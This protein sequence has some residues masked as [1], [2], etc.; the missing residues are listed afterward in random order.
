M[1]PDLDRLERMRAKHREFE[2]VALRMKG[3]TRHVEVTKRGV[4][5]HVVESGN[6][7][8]RWPTSYGSGPPKVR[9]ESLHCQ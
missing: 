5:Q 6:A 4:R 1:S 3:S 8:V 9:Y 2:A 7:V